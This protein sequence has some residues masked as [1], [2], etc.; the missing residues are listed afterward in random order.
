MRTPELH[1]PN[2]NTFQIAKE[3]YP[4][5]Y[6]SIP[7]SEIKQALKD[8]YR[9]N[10]NELSEN[11]NFSFT[12]K[13][14]SNGVDY[15]LKV[16]PN[17]TGDAKSEAF[18]KNN[19]PISKISI[20]KI[21]VEERKIREDQEIREK[22]TGE[23]RSV[24]MD[25]FRSNPSEEA[26]GRD[27]FYNKNLSK[28]ATASFGAPENEIK[29]TI[30]NQDTLK[31][32]SRIKEQALLSLSSE[33]G[34]GSESV[35]GSGSSQSP[36]TIRVVG[37]LTPSPIDDVEIKKITIDTSSQT[38]TQ[39]AIS[40]PT[41]TEATVKPQEPSGQIQLAQLLEERIETIEGSV[42][43]L[44][45]TLVKTS[46]QTKLLLQKSINDSERL[47]KLSELVTNLENALSRMQ[48]TQQKQSPSL[49]QEDK[50]IQT[51][52]QAIT[53][54][55]KLKSETWLDIDNSTALAEKDSNSSG[56]SRLGKTWL[57]NLDR[58]KTPDSQQII[59]T[60][61]TSIPRGKGETWLQ[62]DRPPIELKTAIADS[63]Q[64]QRISEWL[65]SS[66][67]K[68]SKSDFL[69][70]PEIKRTSPELVSLSGLEI[71][72]KTNS[73][74]SASPKTLSALQLIEMRKERNR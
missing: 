10:P 54:G 8:Y 72:E 53:S 23:I 69:P 59:P 18:D 73:L 50:T 35:S 15:K 28:I 25:Y 14:E 41:Q 13:Y 2:Q 61:T 38:E 62:A 65:P 3:D 16:I 4:D 24:L 48:E 64:L 40:K 74:S 42:T 55:Q 68:L 6:R 36:K 17:Q 39:I 32:I 11:K 29:F 44:Q 51:S 19:K 21:K 20:D 31:E 67:N 47:S 9:A 49:P 66:E 57:P 37:S 52:Q 1:S 26:Q 71:I 12:Y 43:S 58:E 46:Y 7:S 70:N 33:S 34:S 56:E 63:Q 45:Q 5:S 22:Q 60:I 27:F 30:T